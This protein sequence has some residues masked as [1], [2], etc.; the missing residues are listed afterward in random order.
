M[1]KAKNTTEMAISMKGP[2][3]MGNQKGRDFTFGA[4]A[5]STRVLSDD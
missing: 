5:V 2:S 1:A 4:M 3:S